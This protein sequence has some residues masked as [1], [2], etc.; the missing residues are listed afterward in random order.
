MVIE[1]EGAPI[2]LTLDDTKPDG[3]VPAIMGWIDSSSQMSKICSSPLCVTWPSLCHIACLGKLQKWLRSFAS[4]KPK[5]QRQQPTTAYRGQQITRWK[6][7]GIFKSFMQKP[8]ILRLDIQK[9]CMWCKK[10]WHW[11]CSNTSEMKYWTC[12][13]KI[14]LLP[15]L[16]IHPCPKVQK[17]VRAD[18]RGEVDAWLRQ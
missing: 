7:T 9:Y 18:Q 4:N 13:W 17:A 15:L 14:T 10:T 6:R 3:S 12:W 1:E 2:G 8:A 11:I 5:C 16:Q